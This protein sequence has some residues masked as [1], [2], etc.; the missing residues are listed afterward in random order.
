[1]AQARSAAY[2]AHC[3]GASP[4]A[5]SRQAPRNSPGP[6]P[7]QKTLIARLVAASGGVFPKRR[8]IEL[9]NIALA[10]IAIRLRIASGGGVC[11][12]FVN[13]S[14]NE[15]SRKKMEQKHNHKTTGNSEHEP[16][17]VCV[18]IEQGVEHEHPK[19]SCEDRDSDRDEHGSRETRE[20]PRKLVMHG[21]ASPPCRVDFY[22]QPL[23]KG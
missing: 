13:R 6:P 16:S 22:G 7:R 12:P 3:R 18:W 10:P 2:P 9:G 19:G 11:L 23:C 14:G 8:G 1:P 17:H 15:A 5:R 21:P 4:L 20:I